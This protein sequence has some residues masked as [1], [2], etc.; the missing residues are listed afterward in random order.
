MF[1]FIR[2]NPSAAVTKR[3]LGLLLVTGMLG[4]FLLLQLALVL[5]VFVKQWAS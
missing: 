2:R 1:R 5:W 4:L 3:G